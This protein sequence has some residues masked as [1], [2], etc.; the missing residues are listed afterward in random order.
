MYR[1]WLEPGRY[2]VAEAGVLLSHVTQTKGKGDM[3]YLGI[4]TGM[5]ALI[6][7]AL[8]GAYHEIV[9]LSRVD[10]AATES[11]TVVGPICET[12]D[13]LGIDRLLPPSSENDVILIANAGAYGQVM[14]SSYNLRDVPPEITI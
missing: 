6:R 4:A 14:S 1:L 13:K 2:L 5:N 11:V 3:R 12:G 10:E 7:P 9:N 8:Y